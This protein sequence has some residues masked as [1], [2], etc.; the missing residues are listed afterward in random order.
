MVSKMIQLTHSASM[1]QHKH[2]RETQLFIVY[3]I[4][5]YSNINILQMCTFIYKLQ[6]KEGNISEH[7]GLYFKIILR[8][9]FT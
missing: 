9:A 3:D 2:F 7:L 8:F 4:Y 5:Q 6:F 1:K